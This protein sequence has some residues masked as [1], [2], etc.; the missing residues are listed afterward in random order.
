MHRGKDIG[1][2]EGMCNVG[3]ATTAE[4]AVVSLFR[5]IV[6]AL[7]AVDLLRFEVGGEPVA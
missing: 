6:C 7:D 2:G 3:F 5:V 1:D 4:L